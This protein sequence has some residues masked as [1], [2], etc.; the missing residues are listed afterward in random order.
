MGQAF[1]KLTGIFPYNPLQLESGFPSTFSDP[2]LAVESCH[3]FSPLS[4]SAHALP[5]V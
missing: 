3:A 1:E 2:K 5:D 4:L